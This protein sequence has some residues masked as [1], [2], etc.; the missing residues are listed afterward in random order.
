MTMPLQLAS[1][2]PG[3]TIMEVQRLVLRCEQ[4]DKPF[5]KRQ[6]L[7]EQLQDRTL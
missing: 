7:P 4:C 5:D 6:S 1:D 3:R 2:E